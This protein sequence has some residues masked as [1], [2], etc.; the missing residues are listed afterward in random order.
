[1]ALP[2]EGASI[3]KAD[4]CPGGDSFRSGDAVHSLRT[5]H[6]LPTRIIARPHLDDRMFF[7]RPGGRFDIFSYLEI[8]R[9]K[10]IPPKIEGC[11]GKKDRGVSICICAE[12]S[13]PVDVV[14][15]GQ[16]CTGL[17]PNLGFQ[18]FALVRYRVHPD[19]DREMGWIGLCDARYSRDQY[20]G[21]GGGEWLYT[22]NMAQH[23]DA[24]N[25]LREI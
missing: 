14:A 13:A 19:K 16:S 10:N 5:F 3:G 6:R 17:D 8:F 4:C 22:S 2:P 23:T 25:V 11:I 15:G 24:P 7:D 18:A 9:E 12:K 21:V 20:L 1:M